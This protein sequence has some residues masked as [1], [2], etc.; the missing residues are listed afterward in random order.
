MLALEYEDNYTSF[1]T[2]LG[3]QDETGFMK[4]LREAVFVNACADPKQAAAELATRDAKLH[5]DAAAAAASMDAEEEEEPEVTAQESGAHT[6]GDGVE[7]A[8]A[9]APPTGIVPTA[10][11]R[12]DDGT[13]VF[14]PGTFRGGCDADASDA[15]YD[16]GDDYDHPEL[17]NAVPKSRSLDLGFREDGGTSREG[18][19]L[20]E[21]LPSR[22]SDPGLGAAGRGDSNRSAL[23]VVP[24]P[25]IGSSGVGGDIETG[26]GV[27]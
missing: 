18:D 17:R 8:V 3:T 19:Q 23:C 7:A 22:S 13:E 27:L 20:R 15:S 24:P 21:R 14:V 9:L 26:G 12:D 5:A 1:A 11:A 10:R 25:R 4:L 16:N 2:K 6:T